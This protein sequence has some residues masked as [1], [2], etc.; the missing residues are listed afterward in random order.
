MENMA[1]WDTLEVVVAVSGKKF[2][3]SNIARRLTERLVL[4]SVRHDAGGLTAQL[5][6]DGS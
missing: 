3:K 1:S 2:Q 6:N 5:A 4:V